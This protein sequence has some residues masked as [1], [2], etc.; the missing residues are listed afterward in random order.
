MQEKKHEV[1][2]SGVPRIENIPKDTIRVFCETVLSEIESY[3]HDEDKEKSKIIY[4]QSAEKE[5]KK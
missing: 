1:I 3:F 2:V 4:E 5:I